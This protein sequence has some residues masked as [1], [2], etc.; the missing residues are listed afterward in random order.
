MET[1]DHLAA[2]SALAQ[3]T[4]LSV[5]RLLVRHEP[6]GLA[7]GELARA[8]GVPQNTLSAHLN[9]LSH[10]GLV[11]GARQSRSIIYRA[12]IE[13]LR[14]LSAF[15][16]EDCCGGHPDLCAPDKAPARCCPAD[17]PE[18]LHHD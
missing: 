11:R 5:F 2:L 3:G 17:S 6:E 13:R 7:A 9:I 10:A 18:G 14:Q 8:L 12:D 1:S 4:R 15:L 16:M